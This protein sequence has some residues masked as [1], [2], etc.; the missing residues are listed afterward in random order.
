MKKILIIIFAFLSFAVT[1]KGQDM[2]FQVDTL[3]SGNIHR[4]HVLVALNGKIV[5]SDSLD[6]AMTQYIEK[7]RS[8]SVSVYRLR[9]F[10]D[11]HQ[12]ARNISEQVALEFSQIYPDV[13]VFRGYVNPYFKVTVGN[14]RTK[15]EAMKFLNQI[16]GQYPSIFLVRETF[17][18]I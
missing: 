18:T 12:N 5:A 11:N 15:S 1:A 4:E 8:R 2:A 7:N 10:F 6:K 9:I 14:F 17:S 16:K 3:D 13:P